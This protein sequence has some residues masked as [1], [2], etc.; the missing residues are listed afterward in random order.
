MWGHARVWVL[1]ALYTEL[2]HAEKRAHKLARTLPSQTRTPTSCFLP[3]R[4]SEHV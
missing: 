2:F 4:A 3:R 1:T